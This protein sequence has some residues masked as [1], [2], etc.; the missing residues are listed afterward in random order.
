V[1]ALYARSPHIPQKVRLLV[2]FL[3]QWFGVKWRSG[4]SLENVTV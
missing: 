4:I 1:T 3:A 2:T